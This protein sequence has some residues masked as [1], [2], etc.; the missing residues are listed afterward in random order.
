MAILL[1]I[2]R[3]V[4]MPAVPLDRVANGGACQYLIGPA[5]Q[6][7]AA[8]YSGQ[9]IPDDPPGLGLGE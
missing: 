4:V 2:P 9:A 8:Q 3:K 5:Q 6:S 1:S 7:P